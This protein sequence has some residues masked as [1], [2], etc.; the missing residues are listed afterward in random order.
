[1]NWQNIN[2]P[3]KYGLCW[4]LNCVKQKD[5][6]YNDF[7]IGMSTLFPAKNNFKITLSSS[8]NTRAWQQKR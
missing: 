8:L 6:L 5:K 1:M 7:R 4:E 2:F 3:R